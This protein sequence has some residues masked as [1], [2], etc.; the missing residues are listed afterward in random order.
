MFEARKTLIF[1][2]RYRGISFIPGKSSFKAFIK[3][4][5]MK[6][7][8]IRKPDDMHIHL[9]QGE[10]MKFYAQAA[11]SVF[12]RAVVMP[13]TIPPVNSAESLKLYEKEIL[14]AAPGLKPLMTFKLYRD[15]KK[16]EVF[17]LKNAGAA[18]GKLYPAG[19][20]TNSEDGIRDWKDIREALSAMEEAG[21][22]LSIHGEDPQSFS[23][24]REKDYLPELYKILENYPDLKVVFEHVSSKEG[25]KAVLEGGNKLAATVTPHHL[26]FTLD[27]LLGGMLNP[28]LFCKPVV[29]TPADRDAVQEAVLSGNS[30]LFFGSDSAPHPEKAKFGKSG[31]AG[32]YNTYA[33]LPLLASFFEK[34]GC[35]DMMEDFTSRFGAEFYGMELNSGFI[36]LEKSEYKVPELS[37]GSV[38]FMAG[39]TLEWRVC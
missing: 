37:G 20:T 27:D 31:S 34:S 23:M 12:A 11:A 28:L 19:A 16:D 29:K 15:M 35:L 10:N 38:P 33:A 3:G 24:D 17:E 1:K 14:K 18:A 32:S 39:E 6:S 21:I 7:I 36:T 5:N 2:S 13:N 9:R 4:N 25:V 22:V 26:L 8:K 30:R